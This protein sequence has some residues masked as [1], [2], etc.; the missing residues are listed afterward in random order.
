MKSS[1]V[2]YRDLNKEFDE[3]VD[4]DGVYLKLKNG[5]KILDAVAGAAVVAIGHGRKEIF[6]SLKEIDQQSLFYANNGSFTHKWQEELA[7]KIISISPKNINKVIFSSSGT[8]ANE[9]AIK[10]ARQYHIS[11]NQ[12]E[13]YKII[14]RK[15]SYHGASLTTLSLSGRSSWREVFSPMMV[16]APQIAAPYA[17]RC[18]F[19]ENECNLSCANQLEEE[20]LNQGKSSVAAFIAEPII[21]T[22]CTGV[23]PHRD[24]YKRIRE[25]CD[26]Y[27]ILFIADE[28]FCGYGRSGSP[29]AITEWE[30]EADIITISKGLGSGYAAIGATLISEK[31]YELF[32]N[33]NTKLIHGSTYSGLPISTYIAIQVFNI[34][35]NEHLFLNAKV[36]G[37][38]LHKQLNKLK[39]K[40]DII[41]DVRGKGLL[42][43]VEFVKENK[44]CF[45]EQENVALKIVNYMREFGV[46]VG[47]GIPFTN[48][49]K[50]SDH[51]QITPPYIINND[52]I[53]DIVN[54]LEYAI[55]KIT[56]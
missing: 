41:G 2:F 52:Q 25:I 55:K 31:I 9:A 12:P 33:K 14:S 49:G 13:K 37:E 19:C 24:Y 23:V 53:D 30:T 5:E 10:I 4:G 18:H 50:H 6:E 35:E 17:F 1:N 29:F 54:S 47:C 40:F 45:N 46:H 38:Y 11:K 7:K 15:Q 27:D 39:E 20:I 51:I 8:E 16:N 36:Q 28:I 42:A 21:G 56:L 22:T 43:G 48:H 44:T 32:Y 26:K 34:I 3:V